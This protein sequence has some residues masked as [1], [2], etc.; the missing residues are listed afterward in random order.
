MRAPVAAKHRG[1][2]FFIIFV[3]IFRQVDLEQQPPNAPSSLNKPDFMDEEGK[4]GVSSSKTAQNKD[5]IPLRGSLP[6]AGDTPS[7]P[8]P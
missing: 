2:K 7:K 5:E 6:P 1:L 8:S 4:M 3:A